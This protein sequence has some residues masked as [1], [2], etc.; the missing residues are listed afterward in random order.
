MKHPSSGISGNGRYSIEE[1]I[2][3][4]ETEALYRAVDHDLE[5]PIALRVIRTDGM[6]P[7]TKQNL[8]TAIRQSSRISHPTIATVLE[9]TDAA[10]S[11]YVAMELQDG[12]PLTRYLEQQHE[13]PLERKLEIMA[14]VAEGLAC[15]HGQGVV[16]GRLHPSDIAVLKSGQAKV[17]NFGRLTP[18]GGGSPDSADL[19]DPVDDTYHAAA[20]C[21]QWLATSRR[22]AGSNALLPFENG[23]PRS[24]REVDPRIP[25][26]VDQ[27]VVSGV[28]PNVASRPPDAAHLAEAF[29]TAA[30]AVGR[31]RTQLIDRLR[32]LRRQVVGLSTELESGGADS[33]EERIHAAIE[34]PPDLMDARAE[35]LD[36]LQQVDLT[37]KLEAVIDRLREVGIARQQA[38]I[39]LSTHEQNAGRS[40]RREPAVDMLP[41]ETANAPL[42]EGVG[43]L[44]M[45]AVTGTPTSASSR[46][47]LRLAASLIVVVTAAVSLSWI[48]GRTDSSAVV[49]GTAELA[50]DTVVRETP[51]TAGNAVTTLTRATTVE[52]LDTLPGEDIAGW[53][54][55]RRADGEGAPGYVELTSLINV[56][57]LD[58]NFD[59]WHSRNMIPDPKSSSVE[60]LEERLSVISRGLNAELPANRDNN[61]LIQMSEAYSVLA[62]RQLPSPQARD[63]VSR[64]TDLF[65]QVRNPEQFTP[66]NLEILSRLELVQASLRSLAQS[67]AADATV[68][69][70][71]VPRVAASPS[72]PSDGDDRLLVAE[73]SFNRGDYARAIRETQWA[74]RIN[75]GDDKAR[76][77]LERA[78]A[79]QDFEA[80]ALGKAARH[81]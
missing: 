27:I 3:V 81:P 16:H 10:D 71:T 43:T 9:L 50:A 52:L 11:I 48:L 72:G 30:A 46:R 61:L 23:Y 60:L 8:L 40:V 1:T 5:R 18:R 74:L 55:V 75:P 69:S 28:S 17:L 19:G 29:R 66:R 37:H 54:R 70:V 42:L 51:E 80:A 79:A 45:D 53:W 24:L 12:E 57:S 77:L 41:L 21:Y 36:Y 14:E 62:Q 73:R 33:S 68:P 31:E 64:A 32:V 63:T 47:W 38:R 78:R 7:A 34:I 65:E 25:L 39:V 20:L 76:K 44:P 35:D 15:A 13:I 49:V 4:R 67:G 22:K 26:A 59:A 56:N 2:A 6:D 58:A